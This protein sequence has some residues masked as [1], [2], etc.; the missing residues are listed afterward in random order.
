MDGETFTVDPDFSVIFGWRS[1]LSLIGLSTGIVGYWLME[2]QWDNEGPNAF[3]VT[4]EIGDDDAVEN[5]ISR[6][7]HNMND[8]DKVVGQ[9][10]HHSGARDLVRVRSDEGTDENYHPEKAAANQPGSSVEAALYHGTP[11]ADIQAGLAKAF[12]MPKIML[13]GLGI[14]SLSFFLDPAIGG[15]RLYANFWNISCF[16]LAAALGP[17]LALPMRSAILQRD[18][19]Y[20]KQAIVAFLAVSV[21]LCIAVIVDPEVDGPW[22]FNAFGSK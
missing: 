17:I 8:P 6:S 16:V 10:F 3:Q 1:T 4:H 22:Y 5:G 19:E 18:F 11:E 9:A 15:F 21:L 13:I 14:W 12:P 7:Y 20:K 2:R